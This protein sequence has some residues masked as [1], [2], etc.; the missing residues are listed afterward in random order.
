MPKT[1]KEL[2]EELARERMRRRQKSHQASE[3]VEKA[4]I[5]LREAERAYKQ[6]LREEREEGNKDLGITPD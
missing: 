2:D 4:K 6:A 3:R 5:E 1:K